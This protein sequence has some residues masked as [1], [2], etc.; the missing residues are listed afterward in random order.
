MSGARIAR[1]TRET[2]IELT[3][4][5]DGQG[6][7]QVDSGVGFLDHMLQLL[8]QHALISLALRCRG[9]LQVDQ[10]HT[11]EDIGIC[12]GQALAQALGDK[13]GIARYGQCLLPMDEALV[14]CALD[15]S[16]RAYLGFDLSIPAQKVGDFDTELVAE[17][18]Q[19]LCRAGGIC[20]HLKQ[21]SGLNSHHIIEAAFKAFARA[22]RQAIAMDPALKGRVNSSKG[23]L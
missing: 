16:G 9:D 5:L 6:Q 1:E 22:L 19:A 7:A 2:S 21:L 4:S 10:H 17:F 23:S 12:L 3:L 20:L 13:A 8:C 18:F 14:L 15:L 11:V